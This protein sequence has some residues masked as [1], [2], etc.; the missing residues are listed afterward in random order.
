MNRYAALAELRW[1][2]T[3]LPYQ[4]WPCVR[5]GSHENWREWSGSD[6]EGGY[7][8]PRSQWGCQ[9]PTSAGGDWGWDL[10]V[11]LSGRGTGKTLTGSHFALRQALE[12]PGLIGGVIAPTHSDLR[13][14]L[15][16]GHTGLLR[17]IPKELCILNQ[18]GNIWHQASSE[19]KLKNG[20]RIRTLAAEKPDRIRGENLAWA[21]CDEL[22]AWTR[23]DYAWEQLEMATRVGNPRFLVTTTP[24]PLPILKA[25][26]KQVGTVSTS[27]T[28]YDNP[29]LPGFMRRNIEKYRGT[30]IGRQEIMGEILEDI[31]GALWTW[32]MIEDARLL[33][34]ELT[35]PI[36][37]RTVTAIDPSGGGSAEAGIITAARYRNRAGILADDSMQG[38]AM[39]W[40]SKA[41]GAADQWGSDRIIGERNFGGDMVESTIRAVD[42]NASYKDVNASR[43]KRQRAE[44]VAA[45]FER[46]LVGML[47][48]F[49]ELEHELTTWVPDMG[50]ASPNRLDAMVWA[51]TELMLQEGGINP[52]HLRVAPGNV[53]RA[54]PW[55]VA[56]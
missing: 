51:L 21:W 12:N 32:K 50:M 34:P 37:G 26:L 14:I 42:K 22:A 30:R 40:A 1:Q 5:C 28:S 29:H 56:S 24:R 7:T 48:S 20:A 39:Q 2:H 31:E 6:G 43:G 4:L 41:I 19:I 13:R 35:D 36:K 45:L 33:A 10:W 54:T 16:E 38:S 8:R 23:L 49:P 47:G 53:T 9:C 17:V 27:A 3:L 11:F 52:E 55:R 44:P 18:M 46:K 25:L 15:L